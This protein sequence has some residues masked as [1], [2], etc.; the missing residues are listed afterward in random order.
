MYITKPKGL[1]KCQWML[2]LSLCLSSCGPIWSRCYV[3]PSNWFVSLTLNSHISSFSWFKIVQFGRNQS[4]KELREFLKAEKCPDEVTSSKMNFIFHIQ[5]VPRLC[6]RLNAHRFVFNIELIGYYYSI[7]FEAF[8]N[9]RYD[10]V[11]SS[12]T[13]GWVHVENTVWS[14]KC[15]ALMFI[16]KFAYTPKNVT[17]F[18]I[19]T[20]AP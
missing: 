7:H 16:G 19:K 20:K 17:A 9:S 4:K 14:V 3:T 5:L 2:S 15:L 6:W 1:C 12:Q 8:A 11:L 18:H 13:M 10:V